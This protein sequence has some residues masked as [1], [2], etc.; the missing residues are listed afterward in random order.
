MR[1]AISVFLAVLAFL[2]VS[3]HEENLSPDEEFEPSANTEDEAGELLDNSL[4]LLE[5][6]EV[7]VRVKKASNTFFTRTFFIRMLRLKFFKGKN[8][9]ESF[10]DLTLSANIYIFNTKKQQP[11]FCQYLK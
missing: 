10:F 8:V 7:H 4:D 3:A 2:T 9:F 6:E 1:C 5:G 11:P